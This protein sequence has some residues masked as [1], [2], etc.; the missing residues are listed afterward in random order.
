MPI[1][2]SHFEWWETSEPDLQE[3]RSR[4]ETEYDLANVVGHPQVVERDP[5]QDHGL[6]S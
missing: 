4:T 2:L 5:H 3:W 1:G 6:E